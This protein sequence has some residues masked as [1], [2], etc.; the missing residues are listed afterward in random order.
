VPDLLEQLESFIR[1]Q[2][3]QA[4]SEEDRE[5]RRRL[6][7][8]VDGLSKRSPDKS[9]REILE[10]L[11]DDDELIAELE[12]EL[13][14]EA[15][16]LEPAAS[17]EDVDGDEDGDGDGDEPEAENGIRWRRVPFEVPRIYSGED[18]PEHVEYLDE[19]GRTQVRSGRR[20][21]QPVAEDWVE[22]DDDDDNAGDEEPDDSE[23]DEQ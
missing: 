21:G 15:E 23:E 2:R 1:E 3:G 22:L 16:S 14:A 19:E 6:E 20:R 5:W 13:E 18:E 9:R 7:E 11:A 10:E 4:A 8:K 12:R 17:T